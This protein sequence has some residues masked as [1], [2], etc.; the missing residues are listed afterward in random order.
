MR[1]RFALGL[2]AFAFVACD[3]SPTAPRR[4]PLR[5]PAASMSHAAGILTRP[6]AAG[7]RGTSSA[8]VTTPSSTA[9]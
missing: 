7:K 6:S 5:N 1:T 2:A 4:I 3:D 9:R 8:A